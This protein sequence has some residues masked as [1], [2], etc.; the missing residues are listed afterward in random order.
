MNKYRK[1]Y[2]KL[3]NDPIRRARLQKKSAE[4]SKKY[5]EVHKAEL[6][7]IKKQ[8][9]AAN[10]EKISLRN[11]EYRARIREHKLQLDREYHRKNKQK[12]REKAK[13]YRETN[14]ERIRKYLAEKRKIDLNYRLSA[15]LRSRLN[16]A[17]RKNIKV[18]SAVRDLGISIEH[19]KKYIAELFTSGMSWNNWGTWHLDH[20]KPLAAFDLS[21][22]EQF[23]VACHYSNYQPLWAVDNL[24]KGAKNLE[25]ANSSP[26][27]PPKSQAV[28]RLSASNFAVVD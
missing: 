5:R 19:F 16:T 9:A 17:I 4:R 28:L 24:I 3:K 10:K 22:R 11:K 20:K 13:V 23:K 2:L 7:S 15:S 8:Y 14:R 27:L 25:S 18:G 12:I 6:P 26:H 21:N 1:H